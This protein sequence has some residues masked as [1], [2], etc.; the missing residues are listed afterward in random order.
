MRKFI[1]TTLLSAGLILAA[2]SSNAQEEH[3]FVKDHPH[4]TLVAKRPTRPSEHHVWVGSEWQW[5]DGRYAET[6]G[7]W[8]APPPGHKTWKAGRWS[9]TKKGTYWVPGRWS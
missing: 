2:A 8:E 4:A 1:F 5:K 7:H 9:S 3:H 6:P